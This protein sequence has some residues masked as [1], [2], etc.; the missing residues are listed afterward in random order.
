MGYPPGCA[1][2]YEK[3][4]EHLIGEPDGRVDDPGIEI[5]IGVK[6]PGNKEIVSQS[7]FLQ[8][9]GDVQQ[10]VLRG[11]LFHQVQS[12]LTDDLGPGIGGLVHAVPKAHQPERVIAV[13]GFIDEIRQGPPGR[14]LFPS[15]SL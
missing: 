15:A 2:D 11:Q 9:Q 10:R 5:D 12:H 3:G 13:L 6:P 7:H 1:P 4:S 8:A 14:L